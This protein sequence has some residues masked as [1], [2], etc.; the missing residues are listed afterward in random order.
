MEP[1]PPP[2]LEDY[3]AQVR[4]ALVALPRPRALVGASLGGLLALRCAREADALVLVN[5][6]PP[7]PWSHAVPARREAEVVPWRQS[8]RLA[9]TPKINDDW[10]LRYEAEYAHQSDVLDAL[11]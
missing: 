10:S 1:Q 4:A 11:V 8:A 5:P 7:A 9:G 6:L 3:A 2:G